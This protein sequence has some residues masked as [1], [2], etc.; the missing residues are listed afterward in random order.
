MAPLGSRATAAVRRHPHWSLVALVVLLAVPYAALGVGWVLDDWF[1]L[2]NAHFH[3]ALAAAGGA[4]W[5]ARP[6]QGAVYFLTFGVIGAH[7]LAI[8]AVQ[9]TLAAISAVLLFRLLRHFLGDGRAL[10]GAALWAILPNHG[11]LVNWPSAVGISVALVLLLAGCLLVVTARPRLATELGAA[12]LLTVAALCYEAVGPAAAAA[13]LLLP[14]LLNRDWR[15]RQAGL[16]WGG[17][18]V[19]GV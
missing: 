10:A 1:A 4:Q 2:R 18:A 15:L 16:C 11:S 12:V 17:L 7:P 6:G 13:A 8:Y 19:A 3:G 9:V 5:L 14:R